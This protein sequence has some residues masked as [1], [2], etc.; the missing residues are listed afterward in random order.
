MNAFRK[1]ESIRKN[2]G[3][4]ALAL[5]D[6]DSK[7]DGMLADIVQAVT[8][9][10]FDAIL[11]GGSL[12]M[13]G[14]FED[15]LALIRSH[16]DLPLIIFPGSSRQLSPLAD[17]VLFLS[18]LSGRNAQYLIGEQ[19]QSA[20]LIYHHGL[21]TIPTGYILLDVVSPSSVEIIS[22]T[23]PL[24]M[25]K[26][27]II[28]AHALAGQYMGMKVIFLEAGSGAANHAGPE[29]V[30]WLTPKLNIPVIVGGG[31]RSAESAAA[32]AESGAGYVVIGNLLEEK[33]N[34]SELKKITF[35]L[36]W[37]RS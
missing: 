13:D 27:D 2:R 37:S 22:H 9:A 18:L 25:S 14:H 35:E 6:P 20:P 28:L 30:R 17:A 7:N 4:G 36:H 15:R 16:C 1:L 19:V 12:I 21:E 29:L 32:L 3:T 34:W 8:S 5:I 23:R 33:A 10:D 24:P 31:V 26:P 11:V